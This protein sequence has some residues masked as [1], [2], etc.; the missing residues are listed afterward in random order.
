M[1]GAAIPL[2]NSTGSPVPD[3]RTRTR[4][5]GDKRSTQRSCTSSPFAAA[6]RPSAA[7]S[8]VLPGRRTP[9][10]SVNRNGIRGLHIIGVLP[11]ARRL[12][13]IKA[14]LRQVL[15]YLEDE[16]FNT[17]RQFKRPDLPDDQFRTVRRRW[18]EAADDAERQ[19]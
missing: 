6:T 18:K 10:R 9:P 19:F 7:R 15:A 11:H 2:M 1:P 3:S 13:D 12:D 4:T 17:L 8:S 16:N 14:E 5:G